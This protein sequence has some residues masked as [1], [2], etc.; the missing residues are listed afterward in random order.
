VRAEL[1]LEPSADAPATA[2]KQGADAPGGAP[3]L[4][5]LLGGDAVE[6]LLHSAGVL[7]NLEDANWNFVR[8]ASVALD[9]LRPRR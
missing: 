8:G 5:K 1:R 4:A 7:E 9:R 6:K 2:T 3:A